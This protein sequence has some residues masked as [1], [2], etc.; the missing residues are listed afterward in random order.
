MLLTNIKNQLTSYR[1]YWEVIVHLG[2]SSMNFSL[3]GY[4]H[5]TLMFSFVMEAHRS[6]KCGIGYNYRG[7]GVERGLGMYSEN[8]YFPTRS[9]SRYPLRTIHM[10]ALTI[11]GILS[12]LFQLVKPRESMVST[13]TSSYLYILIA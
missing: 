10:H 5:S 6:L 1:W 9:I 3:G 11:R 4:P 7:D 2:W 12:Y 8:I 13:I